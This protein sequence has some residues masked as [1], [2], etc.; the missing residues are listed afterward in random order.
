MVVLDEADEMLKMGFQ[1]DI[2]WILKQAP[3]E[4][5]TALFSATMPREVRRIA[6]RYLRNPVN[7]EIAHR[8]MTVP[9]VDSAT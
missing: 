7:V 8:T 1:E 9:T 2:E 4:R 5:Q 3:A 6:E